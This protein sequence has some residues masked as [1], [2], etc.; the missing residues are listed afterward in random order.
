MALVVILGVGALGSHVVQFLRSCDATIRVVD[1]DRIERK[2]VASQFHSKT[3]VG[4][5]KVGS[6]A[7]TMQF[8]FGLKIETIPHELKGDNVDK[9]LGGAD[10][11]IECFDN[12]ASRRL[13][14]GYVREHG[15]PCLHGAVD[16]D[17]SFGRAIWDENFVIDDEDGAGAATC[18]DGENLPFIGV[19]S[20]IIARA[21]QV[22]LADGKRLGFSISPNGAIRT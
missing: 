17:G 18:E 15:I 13:V 3:G 5:S 2:N 1:F 6:L 4:R 14:Q 10:L 12:G 8:L 7:Q 22:F 9:L 19:V 11:V 20:S 16:A 21:A